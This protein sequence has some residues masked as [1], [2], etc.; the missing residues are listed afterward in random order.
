MHPLGLGVLIRVFQSE[1]PVGDDAELNAVP[2]LYA[3]LE[4]LLFRTKRKLV[5]V[6]KCDAVTFS[7]GEFK[8]HH[9]VGNQKRV[10]KENPANSTVLLAPRHF[11]KIFAKFMLQKYPTFIS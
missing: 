6:E 4:R 11:A 10:F 7:A 3:P 2:R 5:F 1:Y 9:H 8:G